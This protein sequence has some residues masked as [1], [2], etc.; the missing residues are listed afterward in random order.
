MP[1]ASRSYQMW[2]LKGCRTCRYRACRYSV[3]IIY[4]YARNS[5]TTILSNMQSGG[6]GVDKLLLLTCMEAPVGWAS[7][8]A[9]TEAATEC[10]ESKHVSHQQ[11]LS[12]LGRAWG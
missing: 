11:C 9:S 3:C 1:Q 8:E 5:T 4:R 6:I 10:T 7:S 12:E 2:R